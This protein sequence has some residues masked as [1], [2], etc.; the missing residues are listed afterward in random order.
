MSTDAKSND[1]KSADA[2]ETKTK[3]GAHARVAEATEEQ[4]AILVWYMLAYFAPV[5][6][7]GGPWTSFVGTALAV[8]A[9]SQLIHAAAAWWLSCE[10]SEADSVL[11]ATLVFV[12]AV[13][14]RCKKA[15]IMIKQREKDGIET[16][17]LETL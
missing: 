16:P 7:K 6:P 17:T 8:C 13:N 12:D 4:F 9:F 14:Y 1:A 3:G 11:P 15:L 10:A 5:E 2:T